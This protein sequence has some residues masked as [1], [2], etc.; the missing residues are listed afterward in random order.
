MNSV[1]LV[2]HGEIEVQPL[3]V[4]STKG[5]VTWLKHF[6]IMTV[7]NVDLQASQS[8]VQQMKKRTK[9]ATSRLLLEYMY[10]DCAPQQYV[11]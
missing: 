7:S 6:H 5:T 1:V 9:E 10:H 2:G 4:C 11:I 8:H 3:V